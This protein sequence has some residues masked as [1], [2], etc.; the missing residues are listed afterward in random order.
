MSKRKKNKIWI[1]ILIGVVAIFGVLIALNSKKGNE[2]RVAVVKP[3]LRNIVETVSANGK[4]QPVTEVKISPDVPGEIIRLDVKEGDSVREGQLLLVINPEIYLTNRDRLQAALNNAKANLAQSKAREEQAR[5]RLETEV[6]PAYE[7]SQSLYQKK[8]IPIAEFQA[9][10]AAYLAAKGEYEASKQLTLAAGYSVKAAEQALREAEESLRRTSIYAP[11]DGIV[12]KLNVQKGER[13]VG[14][15]QMAGTE[16]MRI[17]DLS[18]ME[19]RVEVSE[20]DIVRVHKGDTCDIE[21]DAFREMKFIGVVTDVGNSAI[22]AAGLA[23]VS[24]DQVTNFEVKIRILRK[25][26]EKLEGGPQMMK[27]G[28]SGTVEI[29]TKTVKGA[30]AVPV[31]CVTSR[32]KTGG[33]VNN[34]ETPYVD[35][36]QDDDEEHIG[37]EEKEVVVFAAKDGKAVKK[38]VKTGIQDRSFIEILEGIDSTDIIISDPYSAISKTLR[39][40]A[41]IKIVEKGTLFKSGSK[42]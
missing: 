32:D 25:S 7:R 41:E 12:S 36:W 8:V 24:A 9:A 4:V 27:P 29:R 17:S 10:E 5:G 3:S 21:I 14:T 39:D 34:S 1:Y 23:T 28:M 33:N 16:M 40:G 11:M 15:A 38:P 6:K 35:G 22:T 19:I 2:T 30:L 18:A 42:K 31:A 26:L 37:E 20:S 13:V